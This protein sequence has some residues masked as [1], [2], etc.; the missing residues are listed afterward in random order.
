MKRVAGTSA[1]AL[2]G[3]LMAVGA[4]ASKLVDIIGSVQYPDFRDGSR[5]TRCTAGKAAGILARNC[6]R[7]PQTSRRVCRPGRAR[8]PATALVLRPSESAGRPA[9]LLSG[10]T[11]GR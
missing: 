3:A 2:V 6:R 8:R 11:R 9:V 5:L 10:G 7:T 1:G 4:P